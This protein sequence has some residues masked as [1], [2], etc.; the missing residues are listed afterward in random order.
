MTKSII[1]IL[2]LTAMFTVGFTA[3]AEDFAG[4][5]RETNSDN[6]LTVER[7]GADQYIIKCPDWTSILFWDKESNA[8]RGVFRYNNSTSKAGKEHAKGGENAVGYH[9]I[10]PKGDGAYEVTYQWSLSPGDG[11]GTFEI[12]KAKGK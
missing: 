8:Y 1:R 6:V 3:R 12:K 4:S 2:A 10:V 7:T 11:H 9:S 5:Y